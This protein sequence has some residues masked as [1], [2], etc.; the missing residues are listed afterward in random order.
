MK[1]M[2]KE[3]SR[4]SWYFIVRGILA[5]ALGFLAFLS[6]SPTLAAL[7]IVFGIYAIFDGAL[8][9]VAGLGASYSPNW[10]LAAGGV[11]AIAIGVFAFFQP[12][13]TA[14][15]IV[16]LV[17]VFAILTGV[18]ELAG[19]ATVGSIIGHRLLLTISGVVALAFG[20]LLIMSPGDGILS[21][22]WLVG[23]YAIFAG[24]MYIAMGFSLRDVAGAAK[25]VESGAT[26][27][28]A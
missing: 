11:A 12:N 15:G 16:I 18:A 20:V 22:L 10:W 19:A 25:S 26:A 23:F 2:S 8:A 1:E 5:I 27:S 24:V 21:V 9:I 3:L 17:G 4:D 6:P 28:H 13:A 7:I 14:E